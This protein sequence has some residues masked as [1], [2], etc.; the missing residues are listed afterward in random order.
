[1]NIVNPRTAQLTA[2]TRDGLFNV[3]NGEISH[4]LENMRFTESILEAFNNIVEISKDR[5]R[6]PTIIGNY[7]VP[8]IKI[9]NFKFTGKTKS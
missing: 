5:K 4:A 8:A 3:K 9:K 7:Y 6:I 2:L 1:M